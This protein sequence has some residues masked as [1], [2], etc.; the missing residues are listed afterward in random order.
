MWINSWFKHISVYL[1][2]V[3]WIN[4]PHIHSFRHTC[5]HCRTQ[6]CSLWHC[7]ADYH[8]PE[9]K[10]KIPLKKKTGN[11]A[12]ISSNS[13]YL[14]CTKTSTCLQKF[15]GYQLEV[16]STSCWLSFHH[17]LGE[18]PKEYHSPC[19]L[20]PAATDS[21]IFFGESMIIWNGRDYHNIYHALVHLRAGLF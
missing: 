1:R 13:W 9:T 8:W 20:H 4:C 19:S 5:S 21:N 15:P 2:F 16:A 6:G 18:M 7:W 10:K 17:Q 3:L 14:T 12:L 11:Y